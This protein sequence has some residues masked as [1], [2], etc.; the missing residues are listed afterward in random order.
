MLKYED[1]QSNLPP[2][3]MKYIVNPYYVSSLSCGG[4]YNNDYSKCFSSGLFP[5]INNDFKFQ[6]Y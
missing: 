2:D 4:L 3:V 5:S 6:C 1:V